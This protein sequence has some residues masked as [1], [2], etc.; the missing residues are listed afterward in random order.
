[1]FKNWGLL[2]FKGIVLIVLAIYTF[3][4]PV[5]ALVGLALYVGI[6]LVITGVILIYAAYKTKDENHE[7]TSA[8][9]EGV[10]DLLF[11]I[12]LITNPGLTASIIP[13]I[14]GFWLMIF[15]V[16]LAINSF[17]AKKDGQSNWTT[18]LITGMALIILGYLMISKLFFG[19][20]A[21]TVW[22]GIGFL[23]VGLINVFIAL[24][25][26]KVKRNINDRL[27]D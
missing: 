18:I 9:I 11:G 26:R 15:G 7:W 16:I 19:A 25:L 5:T 12:I 14:I 20:F 2:L 6:S 3:I 10:I 23:I 21:I 1:M 27:I 8:L 13:F 17:K 22:L 4:H 24:G